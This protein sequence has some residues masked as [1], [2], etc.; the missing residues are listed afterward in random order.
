[1]N[2]QAGDFGIR[3]LQ[4]FDTHPVQFVDAEI[5]EAFDRAD[6][7]AFMLIPVHEVDSPKG[8]QKEDNQSCKD[9]YQRSENLQENPH[10]SPCCETELGV[11]LTLFLPIRPSPE[12]NFRT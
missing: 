11:S 6:Q 1:M 8:E 4:E 7:N 12:P 10:S 2:F 3:M 9:S 5:A